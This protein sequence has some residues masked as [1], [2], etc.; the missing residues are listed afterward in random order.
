[1]KEEMKA[2]RGARNE[3]R[4]PENCFWHELETGEIAIVTSLPPKKRIYRKSV[5]SG[6]EGRVWRR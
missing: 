3:K 4:I 5:L 2:G 6:L 1:M